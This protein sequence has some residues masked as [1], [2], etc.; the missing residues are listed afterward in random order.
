MTP[1]NP[2]APSISVARFVTVELAAQAT[3]LSQKAIR[4]K[5]EDGIWIEG[6]EYR[7]QIDD[8]RIYVDMKGYEKWVVKELA[9]KYAKS[10]CASGSNGKASGV[11][12]P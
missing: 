7:R 10:P 8:G 2:A 9:S 11:G 12:K 4:R 5:I 1:F 6:S 3:G